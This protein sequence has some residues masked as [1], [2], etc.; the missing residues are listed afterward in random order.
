MSTV[1][2]AKRREFHP[3]ERLEVQ[4]AKRFTGF[5]LDEIRSRQDMIRAHVFSSEGD[6]D[7]VAG[8]RVGAIKEEVDTGDVP[9]DEARG[10]ESRLGCVQIGAVDQQVHVLREATA[11][12]STRP[13]QAAIAFP[14]MTAY[15][16]PAVSSAPVA[17][18]KRFLTSSTPRMVRSQDCKPSGNIVITLSYHAEESLVRSPPGPERPSWRLGFATT[19]EAK[20][21]VRTLW[22]SA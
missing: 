17:R 13:T 4:H 12:W 16:M 5:R 19:R 11:D 22:S 9:I 7:S 10:F 6:V 20:Q 1:L 15:A 8:F 2:V 3:H 18:N 21:G 14:P